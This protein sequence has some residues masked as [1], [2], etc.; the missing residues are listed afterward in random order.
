MR[1]QI[2]RRI[3][4]LSADLE[5]QEQRVAQLRAALEQAVQASVSMRGGVIEL[6]R[7]LEQG[8]GETGAEP[9]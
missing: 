9:E 1:E 7:L 3:A 4:A 2:E 5:R 8:E 6:R